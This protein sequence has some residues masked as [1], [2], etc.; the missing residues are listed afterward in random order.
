MSSLPSASMASSFDET[1]RVVEMRAG[2]RRSLNRI[3]DARDYSDGS[4]V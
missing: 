4:G 3:T 1:R 2:V